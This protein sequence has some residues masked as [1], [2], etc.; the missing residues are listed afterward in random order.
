ML[1]YDTG[2]IFLIIYFHIT[3]LQGFSRVMTLPAGRITRSPKHRG[4]SRVGSRGVRNLMGRVQSGQ[5]VFKSHESF[6]PDPTRKKWPDPRKALL[7]WYIVFGLMQ[8]FNW[9]PPDPLLL[10]SKVCFTTFLVVHLISRIVHHVRRI[11]LPKVNFLG[12]DIELSQ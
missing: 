8:L 1:G 3:I 9:G 5:E 11:L 10:K 2:S 12:G 7:F 4:S 6:R